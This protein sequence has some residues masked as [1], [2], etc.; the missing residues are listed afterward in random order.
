M[1]FNSY[2]FVFAFL[3]IMLLGFHL[4]GRRDH[5][6][7]ILWLVV[8]SLF[9]YG[10][11]NPAYLLL[12]VGSMVLNFSIGRALGRMTE[13]DS[14]RRLLLSLGVGLNLAV[15]G[16]YKYAGFAVETWDLMT[17][18]S[19]ETLKIFLPLAISFFTFQQ[20]AYLVDAFKGISKETDFLNY[21]LFVSFFPQLIAGPIVHHEEML[22]QFR[23]QLQLKGL[24]MS[25]G[26]SYFCMGLF[27]KVMLADT[28]APVASG[29]FNAAKLGTD[30]TFMVAWAG[31]LAY[32]LQL[33]FD[34]SGY[35]DMAIGIGRMFGIR[36]PLNFHSPYKA[37]NIVDFWRR[38]HITLSRFLRDY[39]YI[40]LGGNR[41]GK[42]R[43]Y[44]NLF[45]TMLLGGLWH[46]AGWAFIFWGGLHGLYL[47]INHAWANIRK[48][49]GWHW[50][51]KLYL[52]GC[53]LATFL[54]VIVGW[55]FFR[56]EDTASARTI[57]RGMCGMNGFQLP[58]GIFKDLNKLGGLGTWLQGK[59]L[60]V[61]RLPLAPSDGETALMAVL[62]LWVFFAP[63]TQQIMNR[64]R[65]AFES[66]TFSD[67]RDCP[68]LFRWRPTLFWALLLGSFFA[69]CIF[70]LGKISEF[71]YYQ[72]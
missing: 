28:M 16:Y 5:R 55:V 2:V 48:S 29:V 12:I 42:V 40:P 46:G 6:L 23:K 64:Y 34:F 25:I 67:N 4:L 72:F 1:L 24:D 31:I 47:M 69:F 26:F 38:W 19:H 30:P 71:L 62:L 52:A 61:V 54:A 18:Q 59:G 14:G 7:T 68:R 32:T 43:R 56:A 10:W 15:L 60:E 13:E 8:G 17:G 39:L 11:W 37:V 50:E 57:L 3:P 70:R 66:Y 65:P 53:R 9:Y 49:R 45:I 44:L 21:C 51:G 35:S 58:Y 63:N 27:K 33:Y 20:I 36:L 22:P 41:K